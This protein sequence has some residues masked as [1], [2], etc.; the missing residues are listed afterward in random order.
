MASRSMRG[1][2]EGIDAD[3]EGR[4]SVNWPTRVWSSWAAAIHSPGSAARSMGQYPP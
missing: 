2:I 3:E 4:P 1:A